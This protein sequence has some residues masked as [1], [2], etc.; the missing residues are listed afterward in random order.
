VDDDDGG[1]GGGGGEAAAEWGDD[2]DAGG[3]F[4][5]GDGEEDADDAEEEEEEKQVMGVPMDLSE[6]DDDDSEVGLY[7]LNLL[8]LTHSAWY[9]PPLSLSSDILAS[10]FLS[11]T[12]CTATTRWGSAR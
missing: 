6:K 1:G 12:T 10:K 9:Q 5:N 7:R 2:D 4:G 3:G 8:D 11:T